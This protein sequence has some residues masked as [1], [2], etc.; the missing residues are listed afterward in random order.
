MEDPLSDK[1]CVSWKALKKRDAAITKINGFYPPGR[2]TK[3][4]TMIANNEILTL[5]LPFYHLQLTALACKSPTLVLGRVCVCVCMHQEISFVDYI[6]K[7]LLMTI[8]RPYSAPVLFN[9]NLLSLAL[10]FLP[11]GS[12]ASTVLHTPHLHYFP[13]MRAPHPPVLII[14]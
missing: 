6:L 14:L 12:S 4:V 13:R 10:L 5:L 7:L 3:V 8:N 11:R 1:R 9:S 2:Q